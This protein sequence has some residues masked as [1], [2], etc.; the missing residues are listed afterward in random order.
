LN[1]WIKKADIS[2]IDKYNESIIIKVLLE[3]DAVIKKN[4]GFITKRVLTQCSIV[5]VIGRYGVGLVTIDVKGAEELGI[6]VV[7]IHMQMLKQ[8]QNIILV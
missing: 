1:F 2:Y 7:G 6:H 8:L 3:K 4:R 5:K